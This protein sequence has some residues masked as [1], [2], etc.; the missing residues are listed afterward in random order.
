MNPSAGPLTI[1]PEKGERT[2]SDKIVSLGF[3]WVRAVDMR[4]ACVA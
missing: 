1:R 4:A 3:G 2:R